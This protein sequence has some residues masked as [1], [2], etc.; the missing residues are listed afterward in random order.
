MKKP[1]L[2]KGRGVADSCELSAHE[3]LRLPVAAEPLRL[4]GGA[5][6]T[7]SLFP[8]A[9]PPLP[10]RPR[11]QGTQPPQERAKRQQREIQPA[12][13]R[14]PFSPIPSAA[15]GAIIPRATLAARHFAPLSKQQQRPPV[16]GRRH[17]VAEGE[18]KPYKA[19]CCFC[20]CNHHGCE[21]KPPQ[22]TRERRH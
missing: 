3:L 14:P 12:P 6:R 19:P 18:E 1:R 22:N 2:A 4:N 13:R 20:C 9:P 15:A 17:I 10:L 8:G 16:G 7:A 5:G 21:E 11:K